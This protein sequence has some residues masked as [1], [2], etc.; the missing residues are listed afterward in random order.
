MLGIFM[1]ILQTR[2]LFG[3]SILFRRIRRMRLI[4]QVSGTTT[5]FEN[6]TASV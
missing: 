6:G 2:D 4:L 3:G 1:G 5:L